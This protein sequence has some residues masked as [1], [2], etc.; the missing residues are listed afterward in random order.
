[1]SG[2]G[3][4]PYQGRVS[5]S[6]GGEGPSPL[7]VPAKKMLFEPIQIGRVSSL[8]EINSEVL[9]FQHEKMK[10]RLQQRQK[11][12]EELHKRIERLETQLHEKTVL[13][14]GINRYWSLLDEDLLIV[15][16]KFD[17]EGTSLNDLGAGEA[18]LS[19]ECQAEA[20]KCLAPF[21]NNCNNELDAVLT[22]R[23]QASRLSIVKIQKVFE[24]LR[25]RNRTIMQGPTSGEVG[26]IAL[27]ADLRELEKENQK[28]HV[29]NV[30]LHQKHQEMSLK[31]KEL[32]DQL[33]IQERKEMELNNRVEDISAEMLKLVSENAKL[34]NMLQNTSEHCQRYQQ[35]VL[36]DDNKSSSQGSSEVKREMSLSQQKEVDTLRK[37]NNSLQELAN[38]RLTELED[39]HR[40]RQEQKKELDRLRQDIRYLPERVIVETVEYKCLQSKFSVVYND[41]QQ[42]RS[43]LCELKQRLLSLKDDHMKHIEQLASEEEGRQTQHKNDMVKMEGTLAQGRKEYELL[44]I[45]LEQTMASNDESAPI[46]REMRVLITSLKNHNEQLKVEVQ[47]QKRKY[48]EACAEISKL[49]R[50]KAEMV[51]GTEP[52]GGGGA[53]SNSSSNSASKTSESDTVK[54]LRSELKKS[55]NVQRD[56]KTLL[57]LY[58]G[59]SKEHREKVE[60]M[61]AERKLRQELE[62]VKKVVASLQPTIQ[63]ERK[64]AAV[65]CGDNSGKRIKSL[66]EQVYTLQ[67]QVTAQKQ[68]EDALVSEMETT[69]QAFEDMQEQNARLLQELREKDDANFKLMAD[70]IKL[71][72]IE[73]LGNEERQLLIEQ[74]TTLTKQ[75]EAQ[76][77]VMKQMEEKEKVVLQTLTSREQETVVKQQAM[78]AYKCKAVE[79][80]QKSTDL[81]LLFDKSQSQLN[82]LQEALLEKSS[83]L[84][85]ESH[86]ARRLQEEVDGMKGKV[87]RL[88]KIE[89]AGNADEVYKEEIR[90]YKEALTC[91]SCKV[92]R[93]DAV[94]TKCYHV[95]CLKCLKTRY[96]TRQRKCPKCNAPFGCNDYHRLY[97][98]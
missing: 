48:K 64:K 8:E 62:E 54:E 35:Q 72:H 59:A 67:R 90:I 31:M 13:F 10:Q 11:T 76:C 3:K 56:M 9:K 36:S 24:N 38:K 61:S 28:I 50:Q 7:P 82:D 69:G 77:E 58:K 1:M 22:Q 96:E 71:H 95:F 27:D 98:T 73:Q 29:L 89:K 70:K 18:I 63:E 43:V 44:K 88:N 15:I 68:E 5:E 39:F 55:L 85:T 41:N 14:N 78:D 40:E 32:E 19:E 80:L 42:L 74:K 65:V 23:V 34:M 97:L 25:L 16:R 83:A 12:E 93:K 92:N 86:K 60:L 4:R 84:E 6:S 57:D 52:G 81:K 17:A 37:E 20:A 30:D 21:Q 46:T 49:K 66:E 51:A 26:R 91:P 45:E 75:I 87:D 79:E 47:R 94:L 53:P 33:A 2:G